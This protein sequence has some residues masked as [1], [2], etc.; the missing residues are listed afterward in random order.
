MI[1]VIKRDKSTADLDIT[2]IRNVVQW[3]CEGLDVNPIALEA[4]LTTE[5]RNGITTRE[6]QNNLINCALKM[7]SV[8]E[9]DW[10]YVA[11]RL[12]IWGL[13]KDTRIKRQFGGY[14]TNTVFTKHQS[15]DFSKY[16]YWQVERGV[17]DKRITE[18]YDEDDD[19]D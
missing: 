13:W 1:Q 9:S 4:G 14:S 11:G 12:H 8:E 7:C 19:E 17:Y 18:I 15:T 5:L 6:I 2:K 10:R 3:S 16:V